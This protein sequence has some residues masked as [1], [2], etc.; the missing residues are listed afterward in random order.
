MLQ[1]AWDNILLRVQ[2]HLRLIGSSLASHNPEISSKIVERPLSTP[3][4]KHL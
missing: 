3:Q 2:I 1:G 4:D